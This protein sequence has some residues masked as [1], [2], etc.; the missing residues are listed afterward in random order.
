MKK[1]V[2]LVLVAVLCFSFAACGKN[3]SDVQSKETDTN[4]SATQFTTDN[5]MYSFGDTITTA[6]GM[7]EFTPVFEGFAE[8]LANW[9][10]KDYMTPEGKISGSTPYEA[11][12]GKVMMYFSGTINYTG[13]SKTNVV[14]DY[15]FTVDYDNGYLFEFVKGEAFNSGKGYHSGCGVT[16]DIQSGKWTYKTSSVFEPLSSNKTR[17]VRFCIEVPEQLEKNTEK[18]IITFSISGEN[19][20]FLLNK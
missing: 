20:K 5:V 1:L 19:Y 10:D 14:F 12:E 11:S 13:D 2:A 3:S 15:D 9:P 7:F 4:S 17:F 16:N 8:T 18:V 6:N